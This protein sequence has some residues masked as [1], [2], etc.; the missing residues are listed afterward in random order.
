MKSRNPSSSLPSLEQS[1]PHS[2]LGLLTHQKRSHDELSR[3][4]KYAKLLEQF[5]LKY[6]SMEVLDGRR[7]RIN[8]K[9]V[10]NFGSAG[11]LGLDLHPKVHV[12]AKAAID[13]WGTHAGCSRVFASQENILQ[14]EAELA[15]FLKAERVL[16]GHNISQ[17]HAGV[18]PALLGDSRSVLFVDKY[19]HTSMY[20][21]CLV[22]AAK[23]AKIVKVDVSKPA[24]LKRKIL[25]SKAERGAL[26]VDGIYSMQG[27]CPNL[28]RLNALCEETGLLLYVDDAHGIGVFGEEG[29]GVHHESKIGFSNCLLVGSLQKAFSSYGGFIAGE[30]ACVDFLRVASKA[31]VFSGTIQPASVE[32]ARAALSVIQSSEGDALREKLKR[33][34]RRLREHLLSLGFET[35]LDDSPIVPVRIGEDVAT[36]MAGRKLFDLGVYVNSVLYPAVPKG[37]GILRISL[38]SCHSESQMET[39]RFAFVQ[40]SG[41]LSKPSVVAK[42]S[43]GWQVVKAHWQGDGYA[44]L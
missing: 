32:G 29:R 37:E 20:Q 14:L 27:H 30:G 31:Y 19:A 39:L 21:A 40:L 26:F 15:K 36:L 33:N 18:I 5:H 22:A 6:T 43:W 8:N 44:G 1:V 24:A 17:I 23:G 42:A 4:K 35:P 25:A 10:I 11:Y 9:E 2:P 13:K 34:S 12:A 38:N 16:I 28:R 3:Q 41:Y 7:V